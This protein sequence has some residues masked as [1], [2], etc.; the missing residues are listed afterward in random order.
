MH[1]IVLGIDLGSSFIK[2]GLLHADANKV[3]DVI[4]KPMPD[5]RVPSCAG[6]FEVDAGEIYSAVKTLIDSYLERFKEIRAMAFSTQMHG[7]VVKLNGCD[8]YLSWQDTRCVD[9]IPGGDQRYID[10][11]ARLYNPSEYADTGLPI[12]PASAFCNLYAQ[13]VRQAFPAGTPVY[14]LGSYLIYQLTGVNR[15]HLTNAAPL[16]MASLLTC[17]WQH[18]LWERAGLGGL[19]LPEVTKEYEPCGFYTYKGRKLEVFPD[20]GDQQAMLLGIGAGTGDVVMNIGTA[21]QLIRVADRFST[22]IHEIRPYPP[23]L[24]LEVISQLP[25]GRNWDVVVS[26]L[27]EIGEKLFKSRLDRN[28]LWQRLSPLFSPGSGQGLEASMD[29]FSQS[30]A[31]E[32]GSLRHLTSENF[33]LSNMLTAFLE[34]QARSYV[35]SLNDLCKD[36]KPSR[37]LFCGGAV[38]NNPFLM[39]I[40][41]RE[42]GLPCQLF[43]GG[44]EALWGLM[45]MIE[46]HPYTASFLS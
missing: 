37:I 10:S 46:P 38:S 36:H 41:K 9:R 20:L 11:L 26:F 28:T 23:G 32:G 17:N 2:A 16:G 7:C 34:D 6:A 8:T 40:I 31:S 3:T 39:E 27:E 33:T 15:C 1:L 25:S 18:E 22:G 43:E 29:F 14:T 21:G 19:T 5:R 12:K 4:R 30:K 13:N 24:Y 45:K 42:T 44:D 35:S